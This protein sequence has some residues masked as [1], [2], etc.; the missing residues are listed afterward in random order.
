MRT[1]LPPIASLTDTKSHRLCTCWRITRKDASVFRFT[2]H[3]APLTI[4]GDGTYV[5]AGGFSAS[6]RQRQEGLQTRNLDCIGIINSNAITHEDLRSGRY[7]EA[8]V[9]EFLV[10]WRYPFAGPIYSVTYW[11]EEVTFDG[12][13]WNAKVT[14]ISRW[15]RIAIGDVYARNCRWDLFDINCG[16][17]VNDFIETVTI[18]AVDTARRVF[19]ASTL[20]SSANDFYNFGAV[21]WQSGLNVGLVGQTKAYVGA[22]KQVTLQLDMPFDI[23]VGD[24]VQMY[25]GC[26]KVIEDC[27]GVAGANGK[28]WGNNLVNYGG[29][30]HIPGTDKILQ[31]PNTK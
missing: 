15:L 27:K 2:D 26:S 30:P 19:R 24:S 31:T 11:I 16:L 25:P 9:E 12:S 13:R 17:N 4:T 29:F 18:T 1:F 22:T 10:D 14:D 23:S 28:P 3:N 8:K 20:S 5:A 6:A 21:A 7:R